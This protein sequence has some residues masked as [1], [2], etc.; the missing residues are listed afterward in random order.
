MS[1]EN[2]VAKK[3][4]LQI[5]KEMKCIFLC[6]ICLNYKFQQINISIGFVETLSFDFYMLGHNKLRVEV[7]VL[8][9]PNL[10]NI[11]IFRVEKW[12]RCRSPLAPQNNLKLV[13]I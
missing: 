7:S 3:R 6:L 1:Q 4:K 9:V 2:F 12:L 8:H 5:W 10:Q 13:T 11:A